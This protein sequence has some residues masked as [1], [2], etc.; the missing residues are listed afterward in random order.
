M[1][2]M[3]SQVLPRHRR[4]GRLTRCGGKH[5]DTAKLQ[6]TRALHGAME[7]C[8]W[9]SGDGSYVVSGVCF[10]VILHL[11]DGRSEA[12]S[13]WIYGGR[14]GGNGGH[15][16][17][18]LGG[19]RFGVVNDTQG[20]GNHVGDYILEKYGQISPGRHIRPNRNGMIEQAIWGRR[21]IS[22]GTN[23]LRGFAIPPSFKMFLFSVPQYEE[24]SQVVKDNQI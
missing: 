19:R 16:V 23:D 22:D 15:V 24:G 2:H 18:D 1:H 9:G 11:N 5:I 7:I 10:R 21:R 3:S 6:I 14:A 20:T 4:A 8:R 12:A 13:A 17:L